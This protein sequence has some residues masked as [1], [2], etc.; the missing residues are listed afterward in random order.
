MHGLQT[1]VALP[2]THE[3]IPPA[4]DHHPADTLAGIRSSAARACGSSPARPSGRL[5]PVQLSHGP[6]CTWHLR[7]DDG[8]NLILPH[9]LAEERASVSR[10]RQCRDRRGG[11]S[12]R[13]RCWYWLRGGDVAVRLEPGTKG[14]ICGGGCHGW[15]PQDRMELRRQR[16]GAHR[17][18]ENRTGKMRPGRADLTGF[19]R[20]PAMRRGMDSRFP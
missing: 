2:K 13:A 1:W 11:R 12:A 20:C 6:S 17:S 7:A 10:Q 5:S 9:A 19:R 8:A 15:A 3:D 16:P 4:F 18:G 14:V